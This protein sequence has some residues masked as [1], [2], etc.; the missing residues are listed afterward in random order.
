MAKEALILK[1]L[2][3]EIPRTISE[4]S[5]L[6]DLSTTYVNNLCNTLAENGAIY[7]RKSGGTWIAWRRLVHR[8]NRPGYDSTMLNYGE[9]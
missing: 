4:L 5:S 1:I 3:D 7:F 6:T 9:K 8:M 2:S